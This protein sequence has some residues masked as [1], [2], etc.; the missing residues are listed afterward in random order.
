MSDPFDLPETAACARVKELLPEAARA[1]H[2]GEDLGEIVPEVARHLKECARCTA[3]VAH[4][5]SPPDPQPVEGVLRVSVDM[6]PSEDFEQ[7]LLK[8]L[9]DPDPITR[10]RSAARLGTHG[11]LAVTL[12]ALAERAAEDREERVRKAA[13]RTLDD[14]DDSVSIPQRVIE[15]WS[16]NPEEAAPFIEGV[17]S[18]LAQEGRGVAELV[19]SEDTVGGA[20]KL[21]GKGGIHGSIKYEKDELWLTLR[22]L[23]EELEDTKPVVALP[24]AL[25]DKAPSVKWP[26]RVPGLVPSTAAVRKGSVKVALATAGRPHPE[27]RRLVQRIYVLNPEARSR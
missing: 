16:R 27:P 21:E 7:A 14:L 18:R 23:P 5:A 12:A 17:L 9:T 11:R 15:E 8:G 19:A 22:D 2:A 4:L 26:G 3:I 24:L 1:L 13:L 6:D 10:E 20:L 25:K